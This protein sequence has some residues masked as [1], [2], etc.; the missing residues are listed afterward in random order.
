MFNE[1]KKSYFFTKVSKTATLGTPHGSHEMFTAY[2][3]MFSESALHVDH[4]NNIENPV[5]GT[6][7]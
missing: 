2:C 5:A 1:Q 4:E 7:I 6:E 3:Y